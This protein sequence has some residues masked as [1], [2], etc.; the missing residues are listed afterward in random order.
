M[1]KKLI[2]YLLIVAAALLLGFGLNFKLKPVTSEVPQI[3]AEK[4]REMIKVKTD[5]HLL[6]VRS[7]GEYQSGHIEGAISLPFNLI[8]EKKLAELVCQDQP[9]VA[10]CSNLE[11]NL[12]LKAAKKIMSLGYAN[13]LEMAGGIEAFDPKLVAKENSEVAHGIVCTDQSDLGAVTKISAV[14]LAGLVDGINPCAIGIIVLLLGTLIVFLNKPRRVLLTGM[15]YIGTVFG[16]YFLLGLFF[17]RILGVLFDQDWYYSVSHW[18][19]LI[20]G[21]ILVVAGLINLKDFFWLGKGISLQ[22]P[23]KVRPFLGHLA[24]QA[25]YPVVILLAV[26]VTLFEAPCSLPLYV[27]TVKLLMD[28]LMGAGEIARYLILY[29]VMFI[30]P[31]FVV[32]IVVKAFQNVVGVQEFQHKG[33][34]YMKLAMGIML[35]VVGGMLVI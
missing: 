26:L 18:I 31:L 29:N 30:L 12:A 24:E 23:Q 19:N 35:L 34:R 10:Y 5:F 9:I 14:I 27:G 32:L 11:C 33:K 25:T 16:T 22:I 7:A 4:V 28:N 1:F 20:L 13:T 6:D 3:S 15:F 2:I 17:Y 8:T 21:I